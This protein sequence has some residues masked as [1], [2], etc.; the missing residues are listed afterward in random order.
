[1][2]KMELTKKWVPYEYLDAPQLITKSGSIDTDEE[3]KAYDKDLHMFVTVFVLDDIPPIQSLGKL[4]EAHRFSCE[5]KAGETPFFNQRQKHSVQIGQLRVGS[6]DGSA[7]FPMLKTDD[8]DVT[9]APT[10]PF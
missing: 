2:S 8:Q 6:A 1:M 5:W 4:C 10:N 7:G 9:P 3:A